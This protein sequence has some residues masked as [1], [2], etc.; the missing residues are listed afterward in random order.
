MRESHSPTDSLLSWWVGGMFYKT[1][2]GFL[3]SE[4]NSRLL[5][6]ALSSE[7]QFKKSTIG[8]TGEHDSR[9]RVSSILND[10]SCFQAVLAQRVLALVPDLI[11]QLGL[12]PFLATGVD[13]QIAAHGEGAF[14]NRHVDLFTDENRDKQ[15]DRLISLVYYFYKEPKSFSGGLLRL[16]PM[17]GVVYGPDE[18]TIDV[19]PEQ[20]KAIAFSSWIPHE[21]LPV[22]CP[23]GKFSDSRFAIN[24]WVLR[25]RSSPQ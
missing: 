11:K 15:A 4:I 5:A 20:D 12:T 14:Y 16:Y 9:N 21:V 17:P 2:D 23:S 8:S 6:Y 25:A 19:V 18:E 24:F 13:T 1:I 22:I 3:G 10:L 7:S